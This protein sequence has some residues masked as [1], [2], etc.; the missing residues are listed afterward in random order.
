M[1]TK[2]LLALTL[3]AAMPAQGIDDEVLALVN[4]G[5]AFLDAGDTFNANIS[6]V[7]AKGV[8]ADK[9]DWDG[10]LTLSD[11]FF[12]IESEWHAKDCFLIASQ[13]G[14]GYADLADGDPDVCDRAI[15]ALGNVALAW[16]AGLMD[17]PM[18]AETFAQMEQMATIAGQN[19]DW[20]EANGCP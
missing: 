7:N 2:L 15:V 9:Q 5:N 19:A 3:F 12:T 10:M 6:F 17:L 1:F 11:R 18:S 4:E 13:I 20:Y 14:H 8:A 16:N